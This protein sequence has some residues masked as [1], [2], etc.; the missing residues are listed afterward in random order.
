MGVRPPDF[1]KYYII[2]FQENKIVEHKRVPMMG[3]VVSGKI[4]SVPLNQNGESRAA[5]KAV[6]NSPLSLRCVV[7]QAKERDCH[8]L[9]AKYMK[10]HRISCVFI[11]N[12]LE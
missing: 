6:H 9:R 5:P 1:Y 8:V 3:A 11:R 10:L 12:T 7:S 4:F 2:F